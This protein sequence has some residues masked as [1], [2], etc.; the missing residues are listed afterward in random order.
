MTRSA[1]LALALL[2]P[3]PALAV[4]YECSYTRYCVEERSCQPSGLTLT[5][6]PRADATQPDEWEMETGGA[7]SARVIPVRQ[8][9]DPLGDSQSFVSPMEFDSIHLVSIFKRGI[10]RYAMHNSVEGIQSQSFHGT[11]EI[12]P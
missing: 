1:L 5:I 4:G 12:V 9:R 6:R 10:T 11:C 3:A 2:A 8:I 7:A